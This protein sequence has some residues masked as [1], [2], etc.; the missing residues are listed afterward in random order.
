[1]SRVE[2][3]RHEILTQVYGY[4]PAARDATRM[5][6]TARRDGELPD[7]GEAEFE[8]ECAY[9]SGKGLIEVEPD[10]VAAAHKR[11]RITAAG[12]EFMESRGLV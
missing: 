7:A 8:R 1:M 4:R 2:T 3:I 6:T 5:V 12:I 10:P 9:L 11:W